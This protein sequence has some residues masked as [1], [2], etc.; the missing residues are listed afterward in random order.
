MV[1]VASRVF[2]MVHCPL[3]ARF[4]LMGWMMQVVLAV[5]LKASYVVSIPKLVVF[6]LDF[7]AMLLIFSLLG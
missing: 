6:P 7:L 2:A 1:A 4:E 3:E 5:A